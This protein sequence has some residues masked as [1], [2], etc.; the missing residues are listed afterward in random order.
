MKKLTKL[1]DFKRKIHGPF[2]MDRGFVCDCKRNAHIYEI[3]RGG[4]LLYHGTNYR[5]AYG[6]F[7][8]FV[9]AYKTLP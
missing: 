2:W 4:I 6:V 7:R 5:K 1:R 8:V 3:F 9:N